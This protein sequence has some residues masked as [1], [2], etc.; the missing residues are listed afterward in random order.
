[1]RSCG[2]QA[3]VPEG[4]GGFRE[5]PEGYT[6]GYGRFRSVL[7]Q[8]PEA[9]S[10]RFGKVLAASE[11]RFRR[12]G[13]N[14]RLCRF[15]GSGSRFPEGFGKF[16]KV[17]V[18]AGASS[19][20]RFCRVSEG[21]GGRVPENSGGCKGSGRFGEVLGGSGRFWRVPES[22][23]PYEQNNAP[24]C[25]FEI[26]KANAHDTAMYMYMYVCMY[27]CAPAVGDTTEAFF[28]SFLYTYCYI[29]F[30]SF[31]FLVLYTFS[32]SACLHARL[33][34]GLFTCV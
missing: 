25:R 20:G 19:G 16:R 5:V 21:A 12:Q 9:S 17:P 34:V 6:E 11:G 26:D 24:M 1:M 31:C 27:V 18:C 29:H 33:P 15:R 22:Q 8:V 3:R 14:V 32:L 13:S 30:Y 7:V 28:I 2:L 23:G 4:S 10:G